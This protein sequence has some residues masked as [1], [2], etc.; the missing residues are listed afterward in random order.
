[1][2]PVPVAGGADGTGRELFAAFRAA[3]GP[4]DAGA[5]VFGGAPVRTEVA[6]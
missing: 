2:L 4:P 5:S 3:V 6:A 1:V